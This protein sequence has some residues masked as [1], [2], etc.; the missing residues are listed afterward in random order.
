MMGANRH[1]RPAGLEARERLEAVTAARADVARAEALLSAARASC[2]GNAHEPAFAAGFE[3]AR[4]RV[5]LCER[6]VD[7]ALDALAQGRPETFS[8]R[9]DA[10]AGR[11]AASAILRGLD[12]NALESSG[13]ARLATIMGPDGAPE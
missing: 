4:R 8:L 2:A 5:R 1:T 6:R 10:E 11:D 12:A 9:K 7:A 13:Q 3:L